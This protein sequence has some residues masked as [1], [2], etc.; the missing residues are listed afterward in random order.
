MSL[1]NYSI[2]SKNNRPCS[3]RLSRLIADRPVFSCPGESA[4]KPGSGASYAPLTPGTILFTYAS[5]D[6][7]R[8]VE[9]RQEPGGEAGL[10]PGGAGSLVES[11]RRMLSSCAEEGRVKTRVLCLLSPRPSRTILFDSQ[12]RKAPCDAETPKAPSGQWIYD[13]D[14]G[15]RTERLR[16]CGLDQRGNWIKAPSREHGR[17]VARRPH[18]E[19]EDAGRSTKQD[20]GRWGTRWLTSI[21]LPSQAGSSAAEHSYRVGSWFDST[22][23]SGPRKSARRGRRFDSCPVLFTTPRFG[24]VTRAHKAAP[25]TVSVGARPAVGFDS[26]P[27]LAAH[28]ETLAASNGCRPGASAV[29]GSWLLGSSRPVGEAGHFSNAS[30][31]LW[32]QVVDVGGATRTDHRLDVRQTAWRWS[33]PGGESGR[34]MCFIFDTGGKDKTLRIGRPI[35]MAVGHRRCLGRPRVSVFTCRFSSKT[36]RCKIGNGSYTTPAGSLG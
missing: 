16:V 35:D 19:R 34:R 7:W 26:P 30:D 2:G 22:E 20:H 27:V 13:C 5:D 12:A 1:L 3:R 23:E 28:F 15:A 10:Q 29:T 25:Y 14:M 31:D 33:K 6:L 8:Q 24:G 21:L 17:S 18:S 4:L 36:N 9:S 11:G 32:R